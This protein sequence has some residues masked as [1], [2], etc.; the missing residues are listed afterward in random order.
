MSF[1]KQ[2]ATAGNMMTYQQ[3]LQ[4]QQQAAAIAK[5][6]NAVNL[7]QR[8][9]ELAGSNLLGNAYASGDDTSGSGGG[10]NVSGGGAS[11]GAPTVSGMPSQ[12][13]TAPPPAS[14]QQGV[15]QNVPMPGATPM[16]PARPAAGQIPTGGMP[17]VPASSLQPPGGAPPVTGTPPQS[18]PQPPRAPQGNISG[19][20]PSPGGGAPGGQQ[21]WYI[22]LA[23]KIK[24]Q[25]PNATGAQI[26]AAINQAGQAVNPALKQQWEQYKVDSTNALKEQKLQLDAQ[27]EKIDMAIANLKVGAEERG[28]DMKAKQ[29]AAADETKRRGQDMLNQYR[30]TL[31]GMKLPATD[32]VNA[33]RYLTEFQEA[34]R[35]YDVMMS[36]V[37][38]TNDPA[39]KAAQQRV[40]AAQA[41]LDNFVDNHVGSGDPMT[42][43]NQPAASSLPKDLPSPQ[44]VAEGTVAK[45]ASGKAVAVIKGGVWAAP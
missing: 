21:P 23:Q 20:N 17:Q 1:V 12:G 8:Q 31:Q 5:A 22:Q 15:P 9:N 25:A 2:L 11:S 43:T 37:G 40:D 27:R 26:T 34:Q 29:A 32:Q 45:D 28:Q 42:S 24:Q 7:Q 41:K 36:K 18:A 3:Q 13:N 30:Q 44:G 10:D 4:A 39:V 35:N 6:I 38:D 14:P 33:R 19:N 16:N